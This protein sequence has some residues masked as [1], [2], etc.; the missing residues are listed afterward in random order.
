[1]N[2]AWEG[3]ALE[4]EPLR[5]HRSN[6]NRD[7][8]YQGSTETS[9]IHQALRHS[10]EPRRSCLP[11]LSYYRAELFYIKNYRTSQNRWDRIRERQQQE[12]QTQIT[13]KSYAFLSLSGSTTLGSLSCDPSTALDFQRTVLDP[14]I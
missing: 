2:L 3:F 9:N 14:D 11:C 7:L 4:L 6:P 13:K 10:L 12:Y 8:H 5:N 1:M